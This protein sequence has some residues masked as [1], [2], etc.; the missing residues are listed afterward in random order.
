MKRVSDRDL[1]ETTRGYSLN[2]MSSLYY[3]TGLGSIL[4]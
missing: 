3:E 2:V 4:I 1:I